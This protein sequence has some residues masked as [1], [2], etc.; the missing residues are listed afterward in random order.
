MK[1]AIKFGSILVAGIMASGIA[2]GMTACNKGGVKIDKTKT[3]LYVFSYNGGV[4]NEWLDH[5]IESFEAKYADKSFEEGKTGVQVIPDK[6][7]DAGTSMVDSFKN[8]NIDVVFNETVRY[9]EWVKKGNLKDITD[10]VTGENELDGNKKIVDKLA[11]DKKAALTARDGKYYALPHYEAF[12]GVVYD[13]DLFK[14][15]KLYFAADRTMDDFILNDTDAKS[16]GPDGKTGTYDDGLP[17]TYSEFWTLCDKMVASN[18]IPFIWSGEEETYSEFLLYA[19][20]ET[21]AG[22]TESKLNYN[23]G[24]GVEND[25]DKTARIVTGFTGDDKNPVPTV[26]EKV[27]TEEN[28]YLMRQTESK[29]RALEFLF[30]IFNTEGYYHKDSIGKLTMS[31]TEAQQTF[32]FSSLENKPIGMLIEGTFWE[33]EAKDSM[34]LAVQSYGDRAK[35]RNF[36][37][38]PL[39]GVYDTKDNKVEVNETNGKKQVYSDYINAYCGISA[40][41]S[42]VRLDLAKK[43]VKYCYSDAGLNEFTKYTGMR[44]GVNYELAPDTTQNL[45]SFYKSVLTAREEAEVITPMSDSPLFMENENTFTLYNYVW[46]SKNYTFPVSAYRGKMT[47]AKTYFDGMKLTAADWANKK[48]TVS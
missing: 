27:I 45:S 32:I 9:N 36:G 38:M 43:F 17:A 10:I 35:N 25:A 2:L 20:S 24:H 29:Y 42:G 16:A 33:T 8:K 14:Q 13:M 47:S 19:L 37:W 3:Q 11:D 15:K 5:T 26:E 21:M 12:R 46:N 40:N 44:R 39:P 1:K 34:E 4:G 28:G 41:C 22:A 31:N 18:V 7:K 30:K 23:F 6:Q 48:Y